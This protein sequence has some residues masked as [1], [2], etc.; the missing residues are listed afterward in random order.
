MSQEQTKKQ[1]SQKQYGR[2]FQEIRHKKNSYILKLK[3]L[4]QH[5]LFQALKVDK[6]DNKKVEK[7][8]KKLW[9]GYYFK[10]KNSPS[11]WQLI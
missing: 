7:S 9:I 3:Y 8:I 2:K 4:G 10:N 11:Y 6:G 1:A 5:E